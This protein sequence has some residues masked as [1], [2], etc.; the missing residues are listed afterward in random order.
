MNTQEMARDYIKKAKRCL[1]EA[2]VAF[3]EKDYPM[4]IRRAQESVELSLKAIL[5]FFSIEY[6]KTHDVSPALPSLQTHSDIPVWFKDKIQNFIEISRELS[7]SRGPA[8]Y[9][10]ETELKPASEIFDESDAKESLDSAEL[11]FN[12]CKRVI[13]ES[14]SN[15]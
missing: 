13:F 5:R 10:L 6:P 7:K 14:D 4:A 15:E 8:Y 12:S 3:N 2:T 9:G 11:V 1:A